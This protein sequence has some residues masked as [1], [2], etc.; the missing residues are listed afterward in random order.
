MYFTIN[1]SCTMKLCTVA[2]SPSSKGLLKGP[3]LASRAMCCSFSSPTL[4]RAVRVEDTAMQ[5]AT[6]Y[7]LDGGCL[8]PFQLPN[9]YTRGAPTGFPSLLEQGVWRVLLLLSDKTQISLCWFQILGGHYNRRAL[10]L[11]C[12]SFPSPTLTRAGRVDGG[13]YC[14]TPF[15]WKDTITK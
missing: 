11:M 1:G 12:C 6:S 14:P 9:P 4:T 15:H 2:T 7:S 5:Y 13:Y 3:F 8:L 10:E